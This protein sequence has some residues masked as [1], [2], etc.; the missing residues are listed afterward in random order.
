MERPTSE[1]GYLMASLKFVQQHQGKLWWAFCLPLLGS[2][3]LLISLFKLG[4]A[5]LEIFTSSI[6]PP[7]W[8]PDWVLSWGTG[9]LG[10]LFAMLLAYLLLVPLTRVCLAPLLGLYA[11]KVYHLRRGEAF[12][13]TQI[14][15]FRFWKNQVIALFGGLI[16]ALYQLP[17]KLFAWILA[18]VIPGGVLVSAG[19]EFAV[20][21]HFVAL[22]NFGLLLMAGPKPVVSPHKLKK[23]LLPLA[24]WVKS[25][26][27]WAGL[28]LC[29]PLFNI[30]FMLINVTAAALILADHGGPE[31]QGVE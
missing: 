29:I 4:R 19:I 11:E 16:L 10:S 21:R 3:G 31:L 15:Q 20:N 1:K 9:L 8:L 5:L 22:D 12:D 30:F 14:W 26:R 2:L 18:L 13:T 24:P 6:T 25:Y 17:L 23:A 7:S 28:M 27:N